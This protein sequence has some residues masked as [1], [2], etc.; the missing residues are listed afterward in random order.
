MKNELSLATREDI[1][2]GRLWDVY[3]DANGGGGWLGANN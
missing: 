2:P 3:V 1:H